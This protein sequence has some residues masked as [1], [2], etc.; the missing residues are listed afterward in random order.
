MVSKIFLN[1][2]GWAIATNPPMVPSADDEAV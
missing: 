2:S 1:E